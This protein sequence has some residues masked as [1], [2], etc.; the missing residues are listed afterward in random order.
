MAAPEGYIYFSTSWMSWSLCLFGWDEI[1][2]PG[3]LTVYLLHHQKGRLSPCTF[4]PYCSARCWDSR[5]LGS[6]PGRGRRMSVLF[7]LSLWVSLCNG[8]PCFLPLCWPALTQHCSLPLF[9]P[10]WPNNAPYP[11]VD[12]DFA[13]TSPDFPS[14]A[15]SSSCLPYYCWCS[16]LSFQSWLGAFF[17]KSLSLV[18]LRRSFPA[19]FRYKA[20]LISYTCLISF[21]FSLCNTKAIQIFSASAAQPSHRTA[22]PINLLLSLKIKVYVLHT[23]SIMEVYAL[24]WKSLFVSVLN[25]L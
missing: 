13:M 17:S 15:S 18:S 12:L 23:K 5:G 24:S 6:G 2:T 9:D 8:P 25:A 20:D 14:F 21:Q 22:S 11:C 10:P 19:S 1:F 4:G 16:F 7:C 3:C